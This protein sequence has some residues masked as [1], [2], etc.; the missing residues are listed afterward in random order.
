M[1]FVVVVVVFVS[2]SLAT[3]NAA[4]TCIRHYF[5]NVMSVQFV[6]LYCSMCASQNY[7]EKSF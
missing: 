4:L 7:I 1:Y 2:Y 3:I 5:P 6:T